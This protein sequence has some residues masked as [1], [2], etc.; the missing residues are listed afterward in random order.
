[1]ADTVTVTPPAPLAP[2]RHN[3]NSLP[4]SRGGPTKV[5]HWHEQ[6]QTFSGARK[7]SWNPSLQESIREPCRTIVTVSV[8]LQKSTV[9]MTAQLLIMST[10][11][12]LERH[13]AVACNSDSLNISPRARWVVCPGPWAVPEGSA[14]GLYIYSPSWFNG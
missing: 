10:D 13:P 12:E 6:L 9:T 5:F 2:R 4:V 14:G 8:S 7:E 3:L 11:A 1:M